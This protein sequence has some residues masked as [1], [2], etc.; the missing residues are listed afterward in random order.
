ML[1]AWYLLNNLLPGIFGGA[2]AL[3]WVWL[4]FWSGRYVSCS[5][6][7]VQREIVP[8]SPHD[9]HDHRIVVFDSTLF[10]SDM[11]HA[12]MTWWNVALVQDCT[13]VTSRCHLCGEHTILATF[14]VTWTI[15]YV[16][17]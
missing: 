6:T 2:A 8:P 15:E 7:G 4:E 14:D 13:R 16:F 5:I 1:Q 17:F 12:F 10:C 3:L 11:I 9:P